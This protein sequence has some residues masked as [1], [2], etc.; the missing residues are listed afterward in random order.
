MSDR[1]FVIYD[2]ETDPYILEGSGKKK[3]KRKIKIPPGISQRQSTKVVIN[4]GTHGNRRLKKKKKK[5]T[6]MTQVPF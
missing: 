2:F 6:I 4:F 5:P 1:P 3:K